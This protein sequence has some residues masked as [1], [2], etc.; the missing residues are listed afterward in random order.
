MED[1]KEKDLHSEDLN[2]VSG[3]YMK[4]GFLGNYLVCDNCGSS[5]KKTLVP[6]NNGHLCT[7]RIKKIEKELGRKIL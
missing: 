6:Y 7:D 4:H 3:G 2:E 5:Y 1:T